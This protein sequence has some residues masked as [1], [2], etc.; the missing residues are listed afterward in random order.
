LPGLGFLSAFY[1]LRRLSLWLIIASHILLTTLKLTG[2][3][4]S[5]FYLLRWLP[6]WLIIA[7]HILLTTL[8]LTGLF[9]SPFYLLRWLPLWLIIASHILLMDRFVSVSII[10]IWPF[11]TPVVIIISRVRISVNSFS[12]PAYPVIVCTVVLTII[13][14]IIPGLPEIVIVSSV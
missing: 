11:K 7:S 4:L 3:F 2:L 13:I 8:K 9:L 1:L 5:A 10:I 12:W 14:I 6:L